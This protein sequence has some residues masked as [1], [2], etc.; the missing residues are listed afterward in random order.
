MRLIFSK[1]QCQAQVKQ[2]HEM[3]MLHEYRAALVLWV[4]W[5]VE[6]DGAFILFIWPGQRAKSGNSRSNY[7]IQDF[8]ANTCLSYPVLS[9]NSQNVIH[10][11]AQ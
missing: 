3:K 10:C 11:Y 4:I 5:E 8:L 7:K 1:G 2:G 6:F 9:R